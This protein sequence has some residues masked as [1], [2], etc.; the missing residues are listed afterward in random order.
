MQL[1]IGVFLGMAMSGTWFVCDLKL[2]GLVF[3]NVFFLIEIH[4][5][6]DH[7]VNSDT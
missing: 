7:S 1:L 6:L 2:I 3:V 4:L 5:F